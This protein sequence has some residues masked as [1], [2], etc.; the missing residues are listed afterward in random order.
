MW[1]LAFNN[2]S[3]RLNEVWHILIDW[4]AS[5]LLEIIII[6]IGAEIIYQLLTKTVN[7]IVHRLTHRPDLF[8]TESDRK[9]RVKTLDSLINAF[10]R[11]LIF[12]IALIMIINEMGINTGPLLASAGIIGVALGFGAQSLIKDFMSGLFIITEN[13]YRV[14]DVI[15]VTTNAAGSV[16]V[17]TVEAITI[18]TTL[19]RELDGKLHHIPN[20]NIL[21]TTNLTMNYAGINEEITVDRK[22][23]INK[24]E[25]VINHVGQEILSEP[26][27]GKKLLEAPHFARIDKITP[28]GIVIKIFGK[29]TPGDQWK[30]KGHFYKKLISSLEK[31]HIKLAE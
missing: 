27:I 26:E 10:L 7:R 12:I 16:I 22:T 30:I 8:P 13:Q 15:E 25:H 2:V 5:H 6:V 23:D 21:I 29:T 1:E 3:K 31:N 9:K 14:G 4:A 20:G 19:L 11:V 18:R 24:L 28:E 17:G